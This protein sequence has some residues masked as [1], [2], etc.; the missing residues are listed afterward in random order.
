MQ[1]SLAFA[2]W[3]TLIAFRELLFLF[4]ISQGGKRKV[5]AAALA[6]ILP[7][8]VNKLNA[9]FCLLSSFNETL[10]YF[11][12]PSRTVTFALYN[13]IRVIYLNMAE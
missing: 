8:F 6:A 5:L 9:F 7:I 3:A 1:S 10:L 11:L 12:F 2:D 13:L 4:S